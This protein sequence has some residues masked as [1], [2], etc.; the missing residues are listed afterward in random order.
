MQGFE[1]TCYIL[2]Y[3]CGFVANMR[4]QS[5]NW[6]QGILWTVFMIMFTPFCTFLEATGAAMSWYYPL[7]KRIGEFHVLRKS[8]LKPATINAAKK[9]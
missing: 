5:T 1:F 4:E 8:V 3:T 2:S 7:Q 9:V 6:W